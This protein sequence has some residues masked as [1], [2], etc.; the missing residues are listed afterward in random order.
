MIRL[1]A[2]ILCCLLPL[3]ACVTN[4]D[5]EFSGGKV[6]P[7]QASQANVNLAI[8]YLK[9]GDRNT[10]MQKVQKAID[11]DSDNANAYVAEALIYNADGEADKANAAYKLAM[12]KS[13]DDP[14]IQNNYAV[15]L[16]QRGQ[17]KESLDYFNK[18]ANNPRYSTPDSAYTNAGLCALHMPDPVLAEQY[19]RK[20]LQLNPNLPE[21]MAQLALMAYGQKKYLTARAFIERFD[22]LMPK[23]RP[24]VLLLGV[25]NERALGNQQGAA[26]YAKQLLRYYPASEQA[27]QL[28]QTVPHG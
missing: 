12:R 19:F 14:E 28:D 1:R 27:Q 7:R 3:S 8:E 25:N 11:L 9:H 5:P 16:C 22:E 17:A 2:L 6:D 18:A 21:P 20:A 26:D 23:S 13:P 24:D 15:F 4:S 10:A